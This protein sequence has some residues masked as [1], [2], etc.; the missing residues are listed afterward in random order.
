MEIGALRIRGQNLIDRFQTLIFPETPIPPEVSSVH[1]IY[2]EDV[3][4]APSAAEALPE[5]LAWTKGR[6]LIAHNAGFDASILAA[7]GVRLRLSLPENPILCTLAAS[8]K[9]LNRRSHALENLVRELDLPSGLH[10]RALEDAQHCWNL[11]LKLQQMANFNDR[12]LGP[13][14]PLNSY[15]PDK[16]RIPA[17][18]RILLEAADHE[19]S[20]DLQYA[21]QDR[22]LMQAR[23][24]PRFFF[25]KGRKVVMEALCHH[26]RHYKSYRLDR[27]VSAHLCMDAPPVALRPRRR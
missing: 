4:A 24:T 9:I 14:R 26:A 12:T 22:R 15:V 17:S 8:R 10:H 6:P 27:I 13:G 23:V 25:G 7:E 16:P 2:D 11:L 19:Y 5:F 1:G 21:L 20:V 3:A 18:R